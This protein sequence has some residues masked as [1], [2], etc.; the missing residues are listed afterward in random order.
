ML[1]CKFRNITM[2]RAA[3]IGSTFGAELHLAMKKYERQATYLAK[4]SPN[5]D[6][7]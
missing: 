5:V 6:T 4:I 1:L 7:Y 3:E 2:L